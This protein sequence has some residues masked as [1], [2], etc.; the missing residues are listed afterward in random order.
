M[1]YAKVI[2]W[3]DRRY[4]DGLEQAFGRP[5]EESSLR[6]SKLQLGEEKIVLL[7]V[8]SGQ[9]F[10][11]RAAASVG[12]ETYGLDISLEAIKISRR[13]CLKSRLVVG[14]GEA[15][16][17]PDRTFD[18]LTCWGAL[19]HHPNIQWA[20]SEFVRVTRLNG[21]ILLRVPNRSFWVYRLKA[22]LGYRIGTEQR[23]IIEH[24]LTLDQWRTLLL[25]SGMTILSITPD[26]W[27][28]RQPFDASNGIFDV[29]KLALRKF[30]LTLAPLSNT[31]QLDFLC[32][33]N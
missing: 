15:L 6:L 26:D 16:P 22:F 17:F 24:L 1:N 5:P 2:T 29:Y 4:R 19:E 8:A 27:F 23:E 30:A 20:L 18:V 25:N 28:L 11:L 7:D 12:H 33:R 14:S 13:I 32:Q 21:K 3:Y 31:Y 9:G 10:F